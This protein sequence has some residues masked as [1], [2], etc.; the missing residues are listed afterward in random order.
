K[1]ELRHRLPAAFGQRARA[2][3]EPLAAFESCT[4]QRMGLE[5]LELLVGRQVRIFVIEMDHE[6]DRKESGVEMIEERAASGAIIERPAEGMLHQ[7]GA[8]LF[9]RDL[10]QLF[11]SEPELLRLA[12]IPKPEPL[13]EHLGEAAAGTLGEQGVFRAQLHAAGEAVLMMPV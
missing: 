12:A 1:G 11:E 6:A 8:M 13:L 10:P 4:H 7:A 2:V 5:A 3:S 9:R